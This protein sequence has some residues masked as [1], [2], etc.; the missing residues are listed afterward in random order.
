MWEAVAIPQTSQALAQLARHVRATAGRQGLLLRC[1]LSWLGSR[2][3]PVAAQ[4]VGKQ[5]NLTRAKRVA[6]R[7][8]IGRE[9]RHAVIILT[10]EPLVLGIADHACDPFARA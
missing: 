9:R 3:V 7:I 1:G 8:L 2:F 6:S 5:P 4:P 10:I